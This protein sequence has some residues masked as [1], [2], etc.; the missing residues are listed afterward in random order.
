MNITQRRVRLIGVDIAAESGATARARV[1]VDWSGVEHVGIAECD[2]ED[3]GT[4][5]CSALATLRALE[6]VVGETGARFG[7]DDFVSARILE[8]EAYLVGTSVRMGEA[9]DYYVGMCL[10][11]DDDDVAAARAVLNSTNRPM[12]K[13]LL[14]E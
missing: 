14:R 13:L 12:T 1:V 11:G 10:C 4:A 2:E 5:R 6:D 7:L 8:S 3:L 9:T